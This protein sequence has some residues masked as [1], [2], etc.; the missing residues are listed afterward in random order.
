MSCSSLTLGFAKVPGLDEL[1]WL[2]VG[3]LMAFR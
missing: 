3:S 2:G 1:E